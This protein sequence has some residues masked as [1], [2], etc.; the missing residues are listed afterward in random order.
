MVAQLRVQLRDADVQILAHH[1][2]FLLVA[3]GIVIAVAVYRPP[4]EVALN[5]VPDG[6][7]VV[8]NHALDFLFAEQSAVAQGLVALLQ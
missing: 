5:I 7:V 3:V 1:L 4:L 2:N 8:A 6:S